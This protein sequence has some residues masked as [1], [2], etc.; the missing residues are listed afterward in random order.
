MPGTKYHAALYGGYRRMS[1][2]KTKKVSASVRQRLL[3]YARS[4]G[5]DFIFV[6][7]TFA[8]ER[9]LFRLSRSP[10]ANYF[11]LKGALLF[12]LWTGDFYRQTRDIDVLLFK[13]QTI[14]SLKTIF[15]DI[16]QLSFV[17]DGLTYL[18][19]RK[20]HLETLR[21][22]LENKIQNLIVMKGGMGKKQR[23]AALNALE[24]LPDHTEKAVLATGRYLGEGF[25]DD[26]L[27]TL[28]L[29]LPISWRGTLNQYAGRL[30]RIHD[31]KKVVVIYDYVD[32]KVP[33]LARMYDRRIKGY[34]SI[35]YKIEANQS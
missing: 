12:K 29:T 8:M 1:P 28:F 19:E 2:Q 3:N 7:R 14:D 26:R 13:S 31:S 16:S 9:L 24:S 4:S 5:Q 33:V 22:L 25:D 32:F 34:R 17:D 35:G 21:S 20:E 10:Y 23:K 6:L 11:V 30:H 18:T 15:Q 27:D